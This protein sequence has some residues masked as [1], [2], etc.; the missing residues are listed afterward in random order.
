MY[1]ISEYGYT[2][3]GIYSAQYKITYLTTSDLAIFS[4]K[5][6]NLGL[7]FLQQPLNLH[8]YWL[9]GLNDTKFLVAVSNFKLNNLK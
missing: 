3:A 5:K 1:L 7:F 2:T 4:E 9:G 8:I 6:T